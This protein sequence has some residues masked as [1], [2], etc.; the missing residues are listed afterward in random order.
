MTHAYALM[1]GKMSPAEAILGNTARSLKTYRLTG[2]TL[3]DP[4]TE[5]ERYGLVAKCL[6]QVMRNRS[7]INHAIGS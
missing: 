4:D 6:G 1:Q 3:P 5:N 2:Y 7:R